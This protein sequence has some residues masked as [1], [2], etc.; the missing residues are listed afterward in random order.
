MKQLL[1]H[2]RQ[3]WSSILSFVIV[4]LPVSWQFS[5]LVAIAKKKKK[6]L[7]VGQSWKA[8]ETFLFG[9]IFIEF[10]RFHSKKKARVES[11]VLSKSGSIEKQ[12]SVVNSKYQRHLF[13]VFKG[14]QDG[15][16]LQLALEVL[17]YQKNYIIII[18]FL[19]MFNPLVFKLICHN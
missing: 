1:L 4:A 5:C 6:K 16:I 12:L 14:S 17:L 7:C 11:R 10:C 13:M 8:R 15:E 3:I 2:M 19:L 9:N 18:I